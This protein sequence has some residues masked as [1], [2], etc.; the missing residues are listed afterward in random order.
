MTTQ[1]LDAILNQYA[2][3][4]GVPIAVLRAI[5][6]VESEG[7]PL[8]IGDNGTS[9]GL[10]QLHIGGQA[11]KAFSDGY[12]QKDLFN[13]AINLRYGMPSISQAW[14]ISS[15][16]FDNS[17]SWWLNFASAS[18]HPGGN[19]NDVATKNE[20]TKLMSAYSGPI[21]FGTYQS[22]TTPTTTSK[23]ISIPFLGTIDIAKYG[24]LILIGTVAIV[25]IGVGVYFM[26][27]KDNV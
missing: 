7:N 19:S 5:V 23:G 11:D 22:S 8:A 15:A 18:G 3:E 12:T 2:T 24:M 1:S 10:L 20:A 9:F 21:S 16:T 6:Q 17:P 25:A 4:Y 13:P 26:V 27:K 14:K